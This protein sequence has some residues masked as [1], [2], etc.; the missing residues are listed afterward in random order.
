M[1][2][3]SLYIKGLLL[4]VGGIIPPISN[5][6]SIPWGYLGRQARDGALLKILF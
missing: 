1:A 6:S 2:I 3:I 4:G 5:F